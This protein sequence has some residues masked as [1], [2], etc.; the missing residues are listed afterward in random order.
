MRFATNF[1]PQAS[2][3]SYLTAIG[4]E[5][6]DQ[7]LGLAIAAEEALV[8]RFPGLAEQLDSGH[9]FP[10]SLLQQYLRKNKIRKAPEYLEDLVYFRRDI[11]AMKNW[12]DPKLVKRFRNGAHTKRF[13]FMDHVYETGLTEKEQEAVDQVVSY[14]GSLKLTKFRLV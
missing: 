10:T 8:Q 14:G 7:A 13:Q 12:D 4:E 1:S 3:Y 6:D 2:P 11:V 9:G 5:L